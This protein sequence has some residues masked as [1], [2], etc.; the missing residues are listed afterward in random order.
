MASPVVTELKSAVTS[1]VVG[2]PDFAG[3]MAHS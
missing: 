2:G 1:V 3:L